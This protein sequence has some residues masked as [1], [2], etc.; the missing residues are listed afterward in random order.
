MAF[1]MVLLLA[2]HLP[3]DLSLYAH[4]CVCCKEF[5]CSMMKRSR[6]QRE[7]AAPWRGPLHCAVPGCPVQEQCEADTQLCAH[8]QPCQERPTGPVAESWESKIQR[9]PLCLRSPTEKK[10]SKMLPTAGWRPSS[11]SGDTEGEIKTKN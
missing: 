7:S 10:K 1:S 3:T 9:F 6:E 8:S 11:G 5:L 2:D 4:Y